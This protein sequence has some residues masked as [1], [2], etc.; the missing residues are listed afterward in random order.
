MA[1]AGKQRTT[2]LRGHFIRKSLGGPDV[3]TSVAICDLSEF[4]VVL[5]RLIFADAVGRLRR[6]TGGCAA[7]MVDFWG[8][9]GKFKDFGGCFNFKV[10]C[11][12]MQMSFFYL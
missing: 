8:P 5:A 4:L 6:P 11:Q 3:D 10:D 7:C 1:N 12:Q 9:G 2:I